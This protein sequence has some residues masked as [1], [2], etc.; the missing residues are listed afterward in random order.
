MKSPVWLGLVAGL[1]LGQAALAEP[2]ADAFTALQQRT[3]EALV[4]LYS[5]VAKPESA[6][7][8]AKRWD[9]LRA[10]VRAPTLAAVGPITFGS[11][12]PVG[13]AEA[14]GRAR[15]QLQHVAALETLAAQREGNV[16][17]AQVWRSLITLPR[18]SDPSEGALLL[19]QEPARVKDP[20]VST[21]LAREYLSWESMRVR[22]LFDKLQALAQSGEATDAFVRGYAQEIAG[23]ARFPE[24][25]VAA[26]GLPTDTTPVPVPPMAAPYDGTETLGRLS[27]WRETIESSLPTLLSENDVNRMERM[28]IRLVKLVPREYRNGVDDGQ[29]LIPLEHREATQFAEQAQSLANELAAV[30]RRREPQA[31]A[32]RHEELVSLFDELRKGVAELVPVT[33]LDKASRRIGDIL[34]SDFGLSARQAGAGG[35]VV[36]ETALEVRSNLNNALAAALGDR[37]QEAETLRAGAYAAFDAEIEARLLPR[38][39]ELALRAERLFLDGRDGQGIKAAL[40][41]RAPAKE[42]N[43]VFDRALR[44]LDESVAVLQVAVSPPVV[45]YT[46][47]SIIARE[48]LEAVVVLAALLA[49]L[50]GVE[51]AG[52]RRGLVAGAWLSV[53]AT[54]LTF[55]LSR[56]LIRSLTSLGERLEAVVSVLAVVVLLIVTNWVFH[57]YYWSGWNAK[58]RSLTRSAVHRRNTRWDRW[59]LVGVGFLTVYREGFETTLFLQSLWLEGQGSA[60]WLGIAGGTLSIA[61]LGL[62]I[63]RFGI[64]LP[65][66]KLLI[67][68]GVLVVSILLTYTGSTVRLFQTVG[69]LPVHPVTGLTL[70]NW[71]GLWFGLYASW[72]GLLLPPLGLAYVA[73][74][75]L[76]VK[77]QANRA[78]RASV[79][80]EVPAGTPA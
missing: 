44:A 56:T 22:Q 57:K 20:A 35:A 72:E 31:Y 50:R 39:P 76:W 38:N 78:R 30:W 55:V 65:Y 2:I 51:N 48:G 9:E 7:E 69:W 49:G 62:L 29:V 21:V 46:A 23:L 63:F 77:W 41:R 8:L 19:Q 45:A 5:D 3:D 58:L 52:T 33:L 24:A 75:W 34:G 1:C 25:L 12:D 18:F 68:T 80:P 17:S 42:L 26:A 14:I 11:A 70:P 6:D 16:P 60:F 53:V 13:L 36:E 10:L 71:A 64:K 27:R 28:L 59:G 43:A 47:F 4:D 74:A 40:D 67:V 73:G 15:A 54:G 66:R 32:K 37:W 61:V 79:E